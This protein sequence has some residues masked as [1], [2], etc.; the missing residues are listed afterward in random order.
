MFNKRDNLLGLDIGSHSVK[1]VQVDARN[2]PYKLMN[3]G[4]IPLPAEAVAEGRIIKSELVAKAIQQLAGHLK[5][6]ERFVAAS[7]S[8]YEVMIKKIELPMMTTVELNNRMQAELGQYIPFNIEEVHVDYQV[9]DFVKDRQNQMEVMLVAAKK[10]SINDHVNLLKLAELQPLVVDVDF[11]ALSNAYEAAYGTSDENVAVMD[12]G[13]NKTLLDI[14]RRGVPIFTRGIS[15]GGSQITANI[16]EALRGSDEEAERIKLGEA[17]DKLPA[18]EMEEIF[19]SLTRDWVREFRRAFDFFYSNFPDSK[20]EK[21]FLCGG[22]C[23]IPGLDRLIQESL[24]TEVE[25]FNPLTHLD[26]DAKVFDPAYLDYVGPQ[27]A[28]ALGL[29]LRK[30][31]EK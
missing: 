31:K 22:S 16:R 21:V 7:I 11:F 8:G 10:D 4:L 18:Q 15:I 5:I 6:K 2:K 14:I 26:R 3:L 17:S 27:M 30:A 13:A 19:V 20:I 29:A 28:I 25:I 12:I 9:L 23:R 24:T 1:M